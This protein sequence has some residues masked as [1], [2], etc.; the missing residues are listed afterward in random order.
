MGDPE[1]GLDCTFPGRQ[2]GSEPQPR[3]SQS[4]M[5]IMTGSTDP[6]DSMVEPL[7]GSARHC[8]LEGGVVHPLAVCLGAGEVALLGLSHI[9]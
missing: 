5:R 8:P 1:V 3:H 9:D 4:L 2:V 7:D 6:I